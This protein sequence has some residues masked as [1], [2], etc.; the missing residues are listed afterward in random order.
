MLPETWNLD[1]IDEKMWKKKLKKCTH[2]TREWDSSHVQ[3]TLFYAPPG[4]SMSYDQVIFLT[5]Y[6]HVKCHK[7]TIDSFNDCWIEIEENDPLTVK[8]KGHRLRGW[9][10]AHL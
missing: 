4:P 7:P 3:S 9:Y 10:F 8:L 6:S 5:H 2:Y 1:I